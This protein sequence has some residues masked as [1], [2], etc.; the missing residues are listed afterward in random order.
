M[1]YKT[2]KY[3]MCSDDFICQAMD[4]I[5]S[6]G[7]LTQLHCENGDVLD[8]LQNKLMSEGCTHPATSPKPARRGPKLRPSTGRSRWER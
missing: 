4:V 7:G 2:R 6:N 5:G 3:R 8:Y 1:T